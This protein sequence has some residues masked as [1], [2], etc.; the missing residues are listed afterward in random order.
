MISLCYKKTYNIINI[1]RYF[2]YYTFR[3][4]LQIKHE[5]KICKCYDVEAANL[6]A[7]KV[8]REKRRNNLIY[9]FK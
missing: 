9:C 7:T 1:I 4:R 6:N 8:N 2:V 3:C 5:I